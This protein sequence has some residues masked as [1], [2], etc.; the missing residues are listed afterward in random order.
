MFP[1]I[2]SKVAFR[3]AIALGMLYLVV[4]YF[5]GPGVPEINSGGPALRAHTILHTTTWTIFWINSLLLG[6]AFVAA[7]FAIVARM[8]DG[9]ASPA[10]SREQVMLRER[11]VSA[12]F[13]G[14]DFDRSA[15]VQIADGYLDLWTFT[16]FTL[17]ID[18]LSQPLDRIAVV[19]L[20]REW[21]RWGS[22][23]F[24][25]NGTDR[26]TCDFHIRW[27]PNR[28]ATDLDRY[29]RSQLG[30]WCFSLSIAAF[31][32]PCPNCSSISLRSH[33]LRS[34]SLS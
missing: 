9:R 8:R 13:S 26:R 25:G 4:S 31:R 6:G 19:W 15:H 16:P 1:R 28:G 32:D 11:F 3:V 24:R 18:R 10:R 12:W 29:C 2:N 34:Y 23:V 7:A 14:K 33:Y 20:V 22:W 27:W 30:C 5:T 21:G 17:S